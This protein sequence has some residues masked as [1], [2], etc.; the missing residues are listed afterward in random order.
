MDNREFSKRIEVDYAPS[1]AHHRGLAWLSIRS[2]RA[3][4]PHS[5]AQLVT[6]WLFKVKALLRCLRV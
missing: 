4:S 1:D 3:A 5:L 2:D 6:T